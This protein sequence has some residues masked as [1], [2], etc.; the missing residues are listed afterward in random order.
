MIDSM[1]LTLR[2]T[3]KFREITGLPLAM[4]SEAQSNPDVDVMMV[5]GA[6]YYIVNVRDDPGLE[7]EQVLDLPISVLMADFGELTEDE[8]E[9][10]PDPLEP[11]SIGESKN[12]TA[13][14]S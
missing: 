2:E 10:V 13:S 9:S 12:V 6:L 11:G 1:S 3:Q 4:I 14:S 7:W 8:P 5:A